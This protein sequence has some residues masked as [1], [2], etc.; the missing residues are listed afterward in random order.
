[1]KH[2]VF[3]SLLIGLSSAISAQAQTVVTG[4]FDD[5]EFQQCQSSTCS[6]AQFQLR[7]YELTVTGTAPFSL[8]FERASAQNV[9]VF[10]L[11][12]EFID[13]PAIS[14]DLTFFQQW[15]ESDFTED[16]TNAIP[17]EGEYTLVLFFED[18]LDFLPGSRDYMV[19][20]GGAF[21]GWGPTV[22]QQLEELGAVAAE[23]GRYTLR[24]VNSNIHDV[25]QRSIAKRKTPKAAAGE[26]ASLMGDVN[27]WVRTSAISADSDAR[28]YDTKMF[29][30]GADIA[31]N[32]SLVAGLAI[33]VGDMNADTTGFSFQGDQ[34]L[35]QPYVGWNYGVWRGSASLVYGDLE[36]DTITSGSGTAAADGEMLALS[37]NVSRDFAI[38]EQ[39]TLTPF[40][41][42]ETGQTKLDAT[43]GSLAGL[44]IGESVNYTETR[45]GVVMTAD[46]GG[47]T[48][49]LGAS[50][51]YYDTDAPTVLTSGQFDDTGW[52]GITE[53]G[54]SVSLDQNTRLD[55]NIQVG[56][57]GTGTSSFSGALQLAITF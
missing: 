42:V 45:L 48:L 36:Y 14:I 52:S 30:F 39:T 2:V 28:T 51:N 44:G 13:S 9:G 6:F 24:L 41:G 8:V 5:P 53:V 54:Y 21:F 33:G 23:G 38:N 31:V 27:A 25:A 26:T 3:G 49:T 57:I 46:V 15:R 56:G 12:G 50:A 34:I 18:G 10:I 22:E 40:V 19:T 43:S 11:P 4:N 20:V 1:M 47:G 7:P 17:P 35:I 32:S 16:Y 29:Q 55:A 37:A